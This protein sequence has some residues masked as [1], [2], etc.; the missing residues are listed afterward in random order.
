MHHSHLIS[1]TRSPL[2]GGALRQEGRGAGVGDERLLF[3]PLSPLESHIEVKAAADLHVDTLLYT[4]H[5][6]AADVAWAG[7]PLLSMPGKTTEY[8]VLA[9]LC[10]SSR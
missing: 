9:V 10:P 2:L 6:T 5:S 1:L 7:V 8:N 3:T 4:A